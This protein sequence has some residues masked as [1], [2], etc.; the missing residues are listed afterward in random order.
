MAPL[1]FVLSPFGVK[2]NIRGSGSID[3]DRI[4]VQALEPA[5]RAAG[6]EPIRADRELTGGIIHKPMFERLLLCE[7]AVADL[8]TANANVFYELGV[9][10]AVRPATTLPIFASGQ[11]I[12]FDVQ[13]VRALPYELGPDGEFEAAEAEKLRDALTKRLQELRTVAAEQ[14]AIDS[15]LLQLLQGYRPPELAHLRTDLVEKSLLAGEAIKRELRTARELKPT[16][17]AIEALQ[18]IEQ[19]LGDLRDAETG[20]VVELYLSY[21]AISAHQE[22]L[23]LHDRMP[24]VLQRTV[25]VREQRAFALNRLAAK[26]ERSG[27]ERLRTEAEQTL[28]QVLQE[29][30]PNGET[31]GLLGRIAKDRWDAARDDPDEADG[32]LQ[33]AIEAYRQGFDADPRDAYPGINAATLL[34]IRGTTE[35]LAIRDRIL[36]VVRYAAELRVRTGGGDYWDRATLVEAAVLANDFVDAQKQLTRVLTAVREAWEPETTA[37][38]LKLI[39]E[40]RAQRNED[41]KALDALRAKLNAKA[42]QVRGA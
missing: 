25:L 22:M 36:P 13:G 23:D 6:L 21:R 16:A 27:R 42:Q 37:R 1:C 38:N 5:I 30:G 14:A 29:I 28:R 19:R 24:R 3:F 34:D 17:K 2:N 32:W 15:P 41:T 31:C 40:A 12:P 8:T 33:Q 26:A 11:P 20:V 35:D 4:Y 39:G 7:F 10:H 9:R 18:T